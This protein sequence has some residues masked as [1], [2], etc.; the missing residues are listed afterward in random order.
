MT[1]SCHREAAPQERRGD[2]VTHEK[3]LRSQRDC[4]VAPLLAMTHSCHREAAPQ[5]RRGDLVTHEQTL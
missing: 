3:T 4:F 1:H 5:E 2:L